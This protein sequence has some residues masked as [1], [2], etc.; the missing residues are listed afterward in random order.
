MRLD[1]SLMGLVDIPMPRSVS[2]RVGVADRWTMERWDTTIRFKPVRFQ[3]PDETI[4]LP[5][6]S[7]SLRITRG[8]GMPRLRTM[9]SYT[10][11]KRFLTGG[12]VVTQQ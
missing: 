1:Q 2:R 4:M 11:Y 6:S 7:T 5:E 10:G 8:A 3:D 12:R 9:T